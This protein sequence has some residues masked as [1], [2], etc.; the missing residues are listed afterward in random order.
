MNTFNHGKELTQKTSYDT[1]APPNLIS[2]ML[3]GW[4]KTAPLKLKPLEHVAGYRERRQKLSRQ[5][6]GDLIAVSSGHLKIRN[7]DCYYV[8]RTS[9]DFYYLTG[10]TEPDAILFLVPEAK[11]GHRSVLF[12]EPNPGKTDATFFTDRIKGELWEGPRLGVEEAKQIFAIEDCR[13]LTELDAFVRAEFSRAGARLRLVRGHSASLEARVEIKNDEQLKRDQVLATA[14]SEMRL[15]KDAYEVRE[16]SRAVAATKRGFEDV[17]ARMKTAKSE[18][19]LEGVFWTRARMEGNDVGYTS[20][21]ASGNH[22]CTLHWKRNDGR[23]RSKDMLLLDAGIEGNSLYTADITRTLP[24]GGKYSKA[25]REIYSLVLKAQKAAMKQVK[26]GNDFMDPNRA[27]MKVLAA[28]LVE[29]GIL[30]TSVEDAL[31]EENQFYRRYTLHNVSHMLGLDVHDCAQARAEAYK[32][33]K[34]VPGMVLTVEPGLYFQPDDETIPTKYRGI[35]GRIEDDVLVTEKG[36]KNLS[37]LIPSDPDRV[38]AWV[39]SIWKQRK[40]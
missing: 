3:K 8:F 32:Y 34:L 40:A 11:G 12:V 20:I 33:G 15:Y 14:L 7:N 25:Q 30:K 31:K 22:S 28:G 24:I 26:P 18:R 2:F 10:C 36:F 6:P 21:V 35:G 4:K 27:A 19:E 38:E 13:P 39:R 17:I 9:S 29:L 37:G 23:L 5:F 1:A 16:L